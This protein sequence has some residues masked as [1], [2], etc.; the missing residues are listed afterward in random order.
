MRRGKSPVKYQ[1]KHAMVLASLLLNLQL[2][3]V[4]FSLQLLKQFYLFPD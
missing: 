4:S 3:R 2:R 1:P